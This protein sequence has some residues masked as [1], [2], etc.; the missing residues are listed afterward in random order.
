ML[1]FDPRRQ[2]TFFE[3]LIRNWHGFHNHRGGRCRDL[4]QHCFRCR[5][6]RRLR[7]T[8]L[9]TLEDARRYATHER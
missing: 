5:D 7:S 4:L 2:A 1:Q 9:A 6:D 8:E 3:E